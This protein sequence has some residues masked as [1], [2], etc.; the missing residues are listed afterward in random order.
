MTRKECV[1]GMTRIIDEDRNKILVRV[2]V[3]YLIHAI[4]YLK[5]QPEIVRCKDCKYWKNGYMN[6][7]VH[8]WLPC[9]E[10]ETNSGWFCGSGE[11]REVNDR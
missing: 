9:M 4:K 2:H 6:Y 10:I 8:P 11:R 1:E 5:D 7:D 3:G